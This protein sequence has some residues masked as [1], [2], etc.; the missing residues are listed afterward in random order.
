MRDLTRRDA[1]TWMYSFKCSFVTGGMRKPK[2]NKLGRK[3]AKIIIISR[4]GSIL[5]EN[6]SC[7]EINENK[8]DTDGAMNAKP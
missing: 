2:R 3:N 5:V 8:C 7:N 6:I 4:W 1:R